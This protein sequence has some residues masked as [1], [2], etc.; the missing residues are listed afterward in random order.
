MRN[1]VIHDEPLYRRGGR[2]GAKTV[3]PLPLDIQPSRMVAEIPQTAAIHS[4]IG[5][6]GLSRE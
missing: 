4:P 6:C 3:L 5:D 1:F 2:N